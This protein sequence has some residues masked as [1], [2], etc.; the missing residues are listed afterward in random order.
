MFIV[1]ITPTL[2]AEFLDTKAINIG[3]Y[4]GNIMCQMI[5]ILSF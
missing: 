3:S 2:L 5:K 4:I 1:T